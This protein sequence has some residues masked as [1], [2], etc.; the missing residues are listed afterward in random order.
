MIFTPNRSH[1]RRIMRLSFRNPKFAKLGAA[2]AA[3]FD[4]EHRAHPSYYLM[5]LVGAASAS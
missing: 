4:S 2:G 3:T 1:F 5:V